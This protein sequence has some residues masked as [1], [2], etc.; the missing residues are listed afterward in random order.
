[1]PIEIVL[2]ISNH[3]ATRYL[4]TAFGIDFMHLPIT[5]ETKAAQ[6]KKMLA[7]VQARGVDLVV[8]ARYMQI[9][10]EEACA[11]L[12]AWIPSG[13]RSGSWPLPIDED[14]IRKSR[15][16]HSQHPSLIETISSPTQ[17][18]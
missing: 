3:T 7:E 4:V 10:T 13:K 6:E 14:L 8:L 2:V 11:A 16:S 1:M 12:P 18:R 15:S 17:N 9:L 5:R